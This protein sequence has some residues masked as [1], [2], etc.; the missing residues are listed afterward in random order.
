MSRRQQAALRGHVR[1]AVNS[2]VE[3]LEGRR[4]L[5]ITAPTLVG[6]TGNQQNPLYED[7]TLYTVNLAGSQQAWLDG[8]QDITSNPP[9]AILKSVNDIGVADG[10]GAL[11][12]EIPNDAT[13]GAF[14]GFRSPNVVDQLAA[15]A[16]SLR[17][18]ETFIGR[19]LNGGSF[20]VPFPE[21]GDNSY[22]GF[23][24]SNELAVVIPGPGG[25]IQRNFTN[26]G[27]SD[28]LGQNAQWNGV[29]GARTIEWDL[30]KFTTTLNGNTVSI[31]EFIQQTSATDARIWFV[32]Q[33]WDTNG[34]QGLMR[35]Y[36]DS[37]TLVNG[38]TETVIGDFDQDPI[39][40]DKVVTF[41]FVP[42]TDAIGFNPESG[43]LHRTSGSESYRNDPTRVGYNDNQFM[44][45]IDLNAADPAASQRAVFNANYE[46]D[47]TNGPYGLPAPRPTWVLPAE[48]RTDEQV[49]PSFQQRGPNEYHALRDLTWSSAEHLFYG[50]DVLGVFKLTA[51]GQSTFLANPAAI[52][53]LK[54]ITF[55]TVG[56]ERKLLVSERDG[57]NLWT[58]D[59]ATGETVGDPV[60]LHDAQDN[61]LPGVLSLVESPDGT[62]LLGL[63][64]NVSDP[65][66]PFVR[67]LVSIDPMTG[68]ATVLGTFDVHIADLA[69]V[70]PRA[71]APA[72]VTQVFVNGPN[73]TANTTQNAAWRGAAGADLAFGYPVPDGA[74]QL[75][76][77]PWNAGVNQ[78]SLRFSQEVASTLDQ[79]DLQVRGS[80]GPITVTGFTYDAPTKTGTW[81]LG[82]TVQLDK[83]R[84]VLSAAGVPSL[85]GEWTNPSTATPAGD[86]YPSGEGS[87][88]GDFNFRVNVLRGDTNGDQQVNALDV[89]DVKKRLLRRPGDGVTGSNAYSIFADLNTDGV[90]NALD[91]AGVKGRLNTRINTLPEPATA[92]LFA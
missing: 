50:A 33:G 11:R 92:L 38:S 24:Q 1:R 83:L 48:R 69:Y 89:A 87:V 71:V 28:S 30:T 2:A 34:N 88:G 15:G 7:E 23:A 44:E 5:A 81:T 20:G 62:Q 91:V 49:D 65:G 4:L 16:T 59:P 70:L 79:A 58:V 52:G 55:F 18:V 76:P 32:T 25:F 56:G 61:P 45:T 12:V 26:A 64:K 73:L 9:D 67:Q 53:E 74:N 41:P 35:F 75:R 46:G 22:N 51:G 8:Y 3:H 39:L 42:D 68:L 63:A 57:A 10:N 29:D 31:P 60:V 47:G 6:I 54:G 17:Y 14:W 80:A 43:L 66:N 37:I 90:I 77:I 27:L 86:A 21:P 40:I 72:E 85:D 84:L 82:S 36:F 78:V 19:E 13:G